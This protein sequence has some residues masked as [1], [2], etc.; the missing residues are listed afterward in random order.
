MKK[1]ISLM[2]P[3]SFY[4]LWNSKFKFHLENLINEII[5]EKVTYQLTETFNNETNY[6]K[7]YIFLESDNS[8]LYIDFNH[9]KNNYMLNYNLIIFD[10]LKIISNKKVLIFIFNSY[11]GINSN[12]DNIYQIYKN[13]NNNQFLRL[14]LSKNFKEQ[15]KT[16][17][18]DVLNFLYNLD[19]KFYLSYLREEN[20]KENIYKS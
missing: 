10:Y 4:Y 18:K 6:L 5:N 9:E 1:Y 3:Y 20:L 19:D 8:I 11:E 12:H 2:N 16:D 7:S 15:N 14:L 17:L 13:K